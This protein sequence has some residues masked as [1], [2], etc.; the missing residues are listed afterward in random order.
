ML[1]CHPARDVP[2]KWFWT[3]KP[4]PVKILCWGLLWWPSSS[5]QQK[6]RHRVRI[7]QRPK[8]VTKSCDIRTKKFLPKSCGNLKKS[9][10][11]FRRAQ[12][13][14]FMPFFESLAGQ[15]RELLSVGKAISTA[16]TALCRDVC[17]LKLCSENRQSSLR[18]SG[19]T[20]FKRLPAST[21][22]H[23]SQVAS[24]ADCDIWRFWRFLEVY[25]LCVAR[26]VKSTL[27]AFAQ[28]FNLFVLPGSGPSQTLAAGHPSEVFVK[29]IKY[30]L[31]DFLI[32]V[33]Y[34]WYIHWYLCICWGIL[35]T[36]SFA[37]QGTLNTATPDPSQPGKMMSVPILV[38]SLRKG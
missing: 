6:F 21:M 14:Q 26:H 28:G 33:L 10:L 13:P 20:T 8:A 4:Y 18:T 16:L 19:W 27:S 5:H 12:P 29:K 3:F 37:T 7:I 9:H 38:R 25:S 23:L 1:Q 15:P 30:D 24:I 2:Q 35:K 17:V 36:T 32:T 31:W 34:S 11:R 22:S